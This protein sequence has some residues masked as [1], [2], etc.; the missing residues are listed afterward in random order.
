MTFIYMTL[1]ESCL[2]QTPHHPMQQRE[3]FGA[4]AAGRA[5]FEVLLHL[6]VFL[7]RERA[8]RGIG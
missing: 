5:D 8:F 3:L 7:A 2:L 4:T 6:M 1:L